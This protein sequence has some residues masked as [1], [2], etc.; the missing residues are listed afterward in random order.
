[1]NVYEHAKCQNKSQVILDKYKE[2]CPECGSRLVFSES[3]FFC[4][5]CGFSQA[6]FSLEKNIFGSD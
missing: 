4:P 3:S 1:M 6:D 5:I 2:H